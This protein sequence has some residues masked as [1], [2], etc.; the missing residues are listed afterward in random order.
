MKIL[1][2]ITSSALDKLLALGTIVL[3]AVSMGHDV[4][5]YATQSAS[6]AF[7][8]DYADKISNYSGDPALSGLINNV[9]SGYNNAVINGR[10]FKWYEMIRQAKEIGS[11]RVY[12][13]TQPFEL[14]G[15][16]VGLG[17]F[18]GIVDELVMIGKYIE[19]L[20]WCDKSVSL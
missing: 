13:C 10:F 2:L 4:A 7:L 8:K 9:V 3:G 6:F 16:K 19:L 18:L 20:E 1:I 11:V 12:V 14:A 17:D 15:I 5:I